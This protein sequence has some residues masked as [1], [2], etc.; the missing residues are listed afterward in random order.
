[1][2]ATIAK[3]ATG[4]FVVL[5]PPWRICLL[6][7]SVLVLNFFDSAFQVKCNT[8][9]LVCDEQ[10]ETLKKVQKDQNTHWRVEASPPVPP[11]LVAA[12]LSF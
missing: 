12:I 5:H 3:A 10:D 1:M 4:F 8:D 9:R 2:P 7:I 6:L 11:S